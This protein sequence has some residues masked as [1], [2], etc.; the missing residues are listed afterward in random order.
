MG[1]VTITAAGFSATPAA[2]PAN[3]PAGVAWP[4]A[5]SPN[6]SKAYTISDAD[7]VRIL[8]WAAATQSVGPT[9]TLGQILL[10]WVAI[11]ATGTIQ[12]VQQHFTA[13]A[14]LG[15]PPTFT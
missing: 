9:P 2:A 13:P 12:A 1:T 15:T 8:T 5:G 3:W 14:T 11:W 6:G 7:W 10:A 4:G